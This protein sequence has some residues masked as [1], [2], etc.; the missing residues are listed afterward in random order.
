MAEQSAPAA[1]NVEQPLARLEPQ[2]AADHLQLVVLGLLERVLPVG[3]VAAR[4]LHLR[5]E[6]QLVELV[7]QVVVKLN[8]VLVLAVRCSAGHLIPRKRMLRLGLLRGGQQERQRA[9]E[10]H[11]LGKLLQPGAGPLDAGGLKKLN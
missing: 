5:V 2:L 11:A 10:E 8:V 1:T 9:F 7:P 6:K 3:E 4:I